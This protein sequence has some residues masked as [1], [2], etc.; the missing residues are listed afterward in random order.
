MSTDFVAVRA[1][2]QTRAGAARSL[3]ESDETH[4]SDHDRFFRLLFE[5]PLAGTH[6]DAQVI[7]AMLTESTLGGGDCFT[8]AGHH[9]AVKD[10][11]HSSYYGA[12]TLSTVDRLRTNS[13]VPPAPSKPMLN[14]RYFTCEERRDIGN[15]IVNGLCD[16]TVAL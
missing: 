12:A 6:S 13:T 2:Q 9:V 4:A 11:F 10:I 7:A 14:A 5:H 1:W 16:G 8:L 3:G 15:K